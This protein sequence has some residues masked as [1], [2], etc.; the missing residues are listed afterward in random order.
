M[1]IACFHYICE[2]TSL[3][4]FCVILHKFSILKLIRVNFWNDA[5]YVVMEKEI[6]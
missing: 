3:D 5:E 1:N 6:L 2:S 4:Y